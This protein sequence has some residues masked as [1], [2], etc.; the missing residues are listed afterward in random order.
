[1]C[2]NAQADPDWLWAV[3]AGSAEEDLGAAISGDGSGNVYVTGLFAGTVVFGSLTLTSA[4]GTDVFVAKLDTS[5]NWLWAV[6]AG[7]ADYEH[8]YGIHTTSGGVSYITGYFQDSADF[9]A[10]TLSSEGETDIYIAKLDA[11]GN[12]LWATRAGGASYDQ[13]NSIS[14]DEGGN[15]YVTGCF[16]GTAHFGF[17]QMTSAGNYDIFIAKADTDG[18]WTWNK[19]AGGIGDDRGYGVDTDGQ[20]N[21]YATGY[22][23][24]S[25]LFGTITLTDGGVFAVKLDTSGN[26]LWARKAD[27]NNYA[28]GTGIVTTADGHSRVTGH[29]EASLGFGASSITSNGDR[30]VFVAALDSGGTWLWAASAGGTD[31][32]TSMGL[33]LDAADNT[34]VTGRF[35]D[36]AAFGASSLTSAGESDIFIA[37]LNPSGIWQWSRRAG[38]SYYDFGNGVA[39]DSGGNIFCT[40]EFWN[41]ADFGA[42]NLTSSGYNDIVVCKLGAGVDADDMVQIP[43]ADLQL[44]VFPNPFRP[45]TNI[46]YTLR[47]AESVSLKIYTSRGQLVR[48]LLN[49]EQPA[50][51][52]SLI[53]NG[54]DDLGKGVASG[55]YLCHVV[56][57]G[58]QETRRILLLK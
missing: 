12:W 58:Q 38:G 45:E 16:Q 8:G 40:G 43:T 34:Y 17:Y 33:T 7:G 31:Y 5:G 49:E 48:S 19:R 11:D 54:K 53:W 21:C 47:K 15:C 18:N 28:S 42:A 1:M 32:D 52:H 39:T 56:C 35:Q 36:T 50:G 25:T 41:T 10:T 30:D 13:G 4:G 20:G 44:C 23:A 46:S 6:R 9:G 2:L 57:N 51:G 37:C 14:V 3:R 22:F 26:W 24:T 55:L 27:G 29:F